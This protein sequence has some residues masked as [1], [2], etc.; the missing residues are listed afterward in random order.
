MQRKKLCASLKF[1]GISGRLTDLWN[2]FFHQYPHWLQKHISGAQVAGNDHIAEAG[3][4]LYLLRAACT[5]RSYSY[6]K[7]ALFDVKSKSVRPP[8]DRW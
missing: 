6:S 8:R 7:L 3:A 4:D 5:H 2:C 1:F